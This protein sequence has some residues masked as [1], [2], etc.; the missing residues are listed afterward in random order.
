[1]MK[2]KIT[3]I[4]ALI[5][6]FTNS[7]QSQTINEIL[8][9][10]ETNNM[11]IQA[12]QKML[13]SKKYEYKNMVMPEGPEFSYGYFPETSSNPG[14]KE[15]FEISQSF[16]MPVFYQNQSALSKLMVEQ[17]KLAFNQVRQT[18][19]LEANN[20]LIELIYSKKMSILIQNRLTDAESVFQAFSKRLDIGDVNVLEVNRSKLNLLHLQNKSKTMQN[21]VRSIIQQLTTL[22]SG[23]ELNIELIDYPAEYNIGF[24]T[25]LAEKQNADPEL[26]YLLKQTES[27]TRLVKVTKNLQLPSFSLG[28]AG[29]TV[30]DEKFRGFV[31]GMSVPLWGG[32]SAI[33]KAKYESQFVTLNNQALQSRIITELQVQIE[34]VKTLKENLDNYSA[35]FNSINNIELLKKSLELGEISTIEYFTEISY[36]YQFYDDLL[37]AEKEYHQAV[38]ELLRFKL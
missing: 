32:S 9:I 5:L 15:T 37:L 17:E 1:M 35:T 7:I 12:A 38:N 2:N 25:L 29:E 3:L 21:E 4:L 16:Q 20:L 33:K 18:V 26:L 23:H 19:L 24:E 10:I 34:K 30:A 14:P 8:K 36:Y 27:S 6:V 31:I 11:D 28:Y 22:N 13:E